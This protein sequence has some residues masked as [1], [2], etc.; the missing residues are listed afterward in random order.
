MKGTFV[1]PQPLSRIVS[2]AKISLHADALADK[3]DMAILVTEIFA[4]WAYIEYQLS[5][6]LVQI[7]GAT[8]TP[9][10]A[11]HSVL[12][13]Q[14]LQA[15]AL[16]AAA[17]AALS[18]HDYQIFSAV[19][20]VVESVQTPRNHLAHWVW[21]RCEQRPDLLVLIDPKM[22]KANE[23]GFRRFAAK[24]FKVAT[25]LVEAETQAKEAREEAKEEL[26]DLDHVLTYSK[27]D[28]ERAKRDMTE[29]R[30]IL[31]GFGSYLNPDFIKKLLTNRV[32]GKLMDK[33]S[34]GD[35][36][37]Q[38]LASLNEFRLFKE[39]MGRIHGR[40]EDNL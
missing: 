18:A 10:L 32:T 29:A 28:L 12:T 4:I 27:D 22:Y 37:A 40:D 11:M 39:A 7:L 15:K 21:G 14:Q 34:A 6:L 16:Q 23:I 25:N 20:S 17:K 8:E 24:E 30:D 35:I 19:T 2:G 26:F 3:P 5:L 1:M 33:I 31:L 13:S 9:A 38:F 36:R